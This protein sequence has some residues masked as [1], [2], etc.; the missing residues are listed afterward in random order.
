MKNIFIALGLASLLLFVFL[1]GIGMLPFLEKNNMNMYSIRVHK[2]VA[3][4]SELPK[5]KTSLLIFFGYVGCETVC[6]VRLK[7]IA[8]IVDQYK[9]NGLHNDLS[10]LFI[11]LDTISNSKQAD[12]FAKSFHP[13]FIGITLPKKELLIM[14]RMFD[15]YFSA[16]LIHKEEINHTQYLYLVKHDDDKS[17]YIENIYTQ[18]PYDQK[19]ILDDLK[20]N[21][22]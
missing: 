18:I 7:E 11:N 19:I 17:F 12:S 15:A 3:L 1:G 20:R 6:S 2:A 9:Q 4:P 21:K 13:E 10:V 16:G 5:L 14:T 22:Q 8:T